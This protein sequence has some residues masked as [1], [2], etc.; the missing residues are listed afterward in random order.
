[1]CKQNYA[2]YKYELMKLLCTLW[3]SLGINNQQ[4]KENDAYIKTRK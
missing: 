3:I 4:V 1:M 2:S